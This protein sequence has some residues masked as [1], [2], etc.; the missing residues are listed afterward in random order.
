MNA[1]IAAIQVVIALAFVS[2]PVI[3]A[4]WGAATQSAAEGSCSR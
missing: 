3:R 4:R 1:T 2:I